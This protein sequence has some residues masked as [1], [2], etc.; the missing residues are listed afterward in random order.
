MEYF[1]VYIMRFNVVCDFKGRCV[2]YFEKKVR[3]KKEELVLE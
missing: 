1:S 3:D 2:G